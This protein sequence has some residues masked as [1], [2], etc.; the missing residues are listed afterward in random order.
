MER[1]SNTPRQAG[2]MIVAGRLSQK[3]APVLLQVYDQMSEP[4]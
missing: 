4:K 2:L 3:M 1:V